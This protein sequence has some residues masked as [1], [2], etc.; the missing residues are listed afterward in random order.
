MSKKSFKF[1]VLL[2]GF[3]FFFTFFA[4]KKALSGKELF[5]ETCRS[6]HID[7]GKAKPVSPSDKIQ[8]QWERFFKEEFEKVHSGLKDPV[9]EKITKEDLEKIKKYTIE[10]AADTEKPET[11]G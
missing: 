9:L 7:G 5:K 10:H 2:F 11:C 1:F 3:A 6:C 8:I 4:G